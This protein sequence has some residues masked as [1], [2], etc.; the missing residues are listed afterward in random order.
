MVEMEVKGVLCLKKN[1][2]PPAIFY[3]GDIQVIIKNI[4]GIPTEGRSIYGFFVTKEDLEKL[5]LKR[6]DY[7][8]MPIR[9][10]RISIW[11]RGGGVYMKELLEM[12][13]V[14]VRKIGIRHMLGWS[15]KA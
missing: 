4:A 10:L 8:I 14:P 5:F 2:Y 7:Y 6:G 9:E 13:K 15:F 12:S 11:K 1:F 3:E